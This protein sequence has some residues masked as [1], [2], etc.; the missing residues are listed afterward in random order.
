M[1]KEHPGLNRAFGMEGSK[2]ANKTGPM[3]E[4]VGMMMKGPR[5]EKKGQGNQ[6]EINRF[7]RQKAYTPKQVWII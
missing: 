2:M 5:E 6:E 1:V 4:S 7:F 3:F